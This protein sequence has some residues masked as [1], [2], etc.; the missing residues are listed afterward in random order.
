MK[1]NLLFLAVWYHVGFYEIFD[2]LPFQI[3]MKWCMRRYNSKN[4]KHV[5][6][7]QNIVHCINPN[8]ILFVKIPDVQEGIIW[9]IS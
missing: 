4:V 3:V 9:K 8:K 1:H 7:E 2:Q 5:E 6:Y